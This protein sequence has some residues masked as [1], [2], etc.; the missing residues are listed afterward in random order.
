MKLIRL[1]RV[2][3]AYLIIGV[4][5]LLFLYNAIGCDNSS[6]TIRQSG[7]DSR[8]H[9]TSRPPGG[10]QT[11]RRLPGH[12]NTAPRIDPKALAQTERQVSGETA[13]LGQIRKEL[14]ALVERAVDTQRA[15]LEAQSKL[16]APQSDNRESE[17]YYG[18][19]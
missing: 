2:A 1:A 4:A 16:P 15:L 18:N 10:T 14:G 11:Q 5:A 6:N 7:K 13:D 19:Q 12:Q 9:S 3:L 8:K 17:V